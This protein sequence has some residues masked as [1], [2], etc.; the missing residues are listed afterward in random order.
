MLSEIEYS[1]RGAQYRLPYTSEEIVKLP[2]SS[3]KIDLL[4]EFYDLN[5]N[6]LFDDHLYSWSFTFNDT[7]KTLRGRK[8][9]LEDVPSGKSSLKIQD[10]YGGGKKLISIHRQ[11][12]WQ[13]FRLPIIAIVALFLLL[14]SLIHLQI[15]RSKERRQATKD[16]NQAQINALQLRALNSQMNPH[17]IY[18]A[19]GS[20]QYFIQTGQM[21]EA[22]E[23]LADFAL[24][25]RRILNAASKDE[26]SIREELSLLELYVRLEQM[27]SDTGFSYEFKV[28][29]EVDLE[30]KIPPMILQPILENAIN[31]GL[32]H[33]ETDKG[34]LR[35]EIIAQED[36]EILVI[37]T[38]NGIG[39]ERSQKLKSTGYTSRG[40][41]LIE[42]RSKLMSQSTKHAV[43]VKV[44]DL[45]PRQEDVGTV[46]KISFGLRNI[47]A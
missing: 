29:D 19:L 21:D 23:Y 7:P 32:G 38:D 14:F 2:Y 4:F 15:K 9:T 30:T 27:R 8:L 34:F 18:N 24:L 43:R 26:I 1:D 12:F 41:S 47:V 3:E 10:K 45:D 25:T 44:D 42:E 11:S 16:R 37:V 6:P 39:R 28:D 33:L 36:E 5:Q 40:L 35:I 13:K 31:H 22:D 20:I 17:F 46:V